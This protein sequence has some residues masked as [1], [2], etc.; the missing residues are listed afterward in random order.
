VERPSGEDEDLLSAHYT[1]FLQSSQKITVA[2]SILGCL[3]LLPVGKFVAVGIVSVCWRVRLNV[4]T[5]DVR[6]STS[7]GW[8][9]CHPSPARWN[10][11]QARLVLAGKSPQKCTVEEKLLKRATMILNIGT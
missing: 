4:E 8:F 3:C 9:K 6:R 2:A 10:H 11:P 7:S 5:S 1:F